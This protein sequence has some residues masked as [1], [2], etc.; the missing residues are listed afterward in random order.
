MLAKI[1]ADGSQSATDYLLNYITIFEL[2]E[3]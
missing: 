2:T 3:R 1:A